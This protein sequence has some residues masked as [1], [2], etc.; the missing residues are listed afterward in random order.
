MY[1]QPAN[2]RCLAFLARTLGYLGYPDQAVQ[3][4]RRALA[5]AE[6]FAYP[7][8]VVLTLYHATSLHHVLRDMH[9]TIQHAEALITLATQHGFDLWRH[10]GTVQRDW[11]LM[12]QGQGEH[13]LP[14]MQQSLQS[15]LDGGAA[16]FRPGFLLLLADAH[17]QVGQMDAGLALL[18]AALQ[19]VEEN[20]VCYIEAEIWRLQGEFWLRQ[21]TP[22]TSRAAT[23]F[24]QAL[25]V[26]RRQQAKW[27]ELR[28]AMSL[29]RLWQ[30][31]GKRDE[32]HQLLAPVYGWFT[33]GFDTADLQDAKAL[34][35]ELGE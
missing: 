25:A 35:A 4:S 20:G 28:A 30:Q 18:T 15:L 23:C 8:S 1:G 17:G 14:Q 24:E 21:A 12:R 13:R 26:A 16:I 31:Q 7:P 29:A 33:E 2:V 27:W 6:G 9:A 5:H 19:E 10:A 3:Q 11:A 34:L 22:E 32:A